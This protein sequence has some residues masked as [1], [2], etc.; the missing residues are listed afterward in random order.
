[1]A[2]LKTIMCETVNEEVKVRLSTKRIG[3]FFGDE[4]PFV[5]CD[6]DECQYA[7]E[8]VA[9]CPLSL[10]LFADEIAAKQKSKNKIPADEG[11]DFS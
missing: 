4:V 8:N 2:R 9:P 10:D 6:Q 7:D 1:M 5:K 3:G 11:F